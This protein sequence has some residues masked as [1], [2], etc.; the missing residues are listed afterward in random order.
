MPNTKIVLNVKAIH[1]KSYK[2]KNTPGDKNTNLYPAI[3]FYKV[4]GAE[5]TDQVE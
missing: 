1:N 2:G 5:N 3:N 4:D